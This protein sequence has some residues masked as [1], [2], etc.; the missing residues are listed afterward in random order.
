MW[1]WCSRSHTTI[2]T[3]S[4]AVRECE[5]VLVVHRRLNSAHK[6]PKAAAGA[7]CASVWC[8]HVHNIKCGYLL[9]WN[10]KDIF[11]FS[12]LFKLLTFELELDFCLGE[13]FSDNIFLRVFWV[14]DRNQYEFSFSAFVLSLVGLSMRKLCESKRWTFLFRLLKRNLILWNRKLKW[15]LVASGTVRTPFGFVVS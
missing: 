2:Q 9:T 10:A 5:W 3:Q 4:R 13:I 14:R 1:S 8:A 15:F 6:Q 12:L 7:S 11:E